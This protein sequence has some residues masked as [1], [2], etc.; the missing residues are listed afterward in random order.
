MTPGLVNTRHHLFKSLLKGVPVA[1]N[2]RLDARLQRVRYA[3]WPHIDAVALRIAARVVLAELVLS[4]TTTISDYHYINDAEAGSNAAGVHFDEAARFGTR[5]GLARGRG[6]KGGINST[7]RRCP[8][9]FASR[10]RT[11]WIE[12]PRRHRAGTTA[13]PLPMTRVAVA[14][15][16]PTFIVKPTALH[17]IAEFARD[18]GLRVHSHLSENHTCIDFTQ[19]R[20]FGPHDPALAPIATGAAPVRHSFCAGKP[21]IADGKVP[22]LDPDALCAEVPDATRR[23]I[24]ARQAAFG[25]G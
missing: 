15:T 25:P 3:F 20:A 4:G 18:K 10:C 19:P 6:T 2:E 1:P 24:A 7:I 13:V 11:F 9:R 21:V 12:S 17:E 16:T 23:L 8:R 14:P 5:F 22:W